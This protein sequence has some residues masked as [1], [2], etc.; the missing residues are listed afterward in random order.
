MSGV[1]AYC[2][3]RPA[4]NRDHVVPKSLRKKREA[5]AKWTKR[6][7]RGHDYACLKEIPSDLLLTVP[8]CFECNIRK[9]ARRLVPRSWADKLPLLNDL[10]PGVPW[11]TWNGNP[12]SDA[13]R[14]TWTEA[15]S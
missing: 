14:L 1:C 11:R 10:F 6:R 13:F 5:E 9:G 2:Q 8:S 7:M 12:K 15:A 4:V 3:K